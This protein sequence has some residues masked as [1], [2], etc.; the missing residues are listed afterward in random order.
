MEKMIES[1]GAKKIH[2]LLLEL[3]QVMLVLY[4]NKSNF[5]SIPADSSTLDH[6]TFLQNPTRVM[7]ENKIYIFNK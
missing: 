5:R 3:L 1:Y 7:A 4:R 6:L 2:M